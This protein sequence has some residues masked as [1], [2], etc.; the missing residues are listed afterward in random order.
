[1]R[2]TFHIRFAFLCCLYCF[3]GCSKQEETPGQY[4]SFDFRMDGSRFIPN[5]G[6]PSSA[7]SFTLAGTI[8][9][10][11]PTPLP[12]GGKYSFAIADGMGEKTVL[13]AGNDTSSEIIA[14]IANGGP[15]IQLLADSTSIY[16][17]HL[18]SRI[19]CFDHE[20]KA[21]WSSAIQG[22]PKANSI[23]AENTVIIDSDSGIAAIN[24]HT[25]KNVW[26]YPTTMSVVGMIYDNKSKLII[27]SLS[28]N[29]S[30]T[31]DS[32][33]C[34]TSS[35]TIKSSIVFETTRII[36]NLCLC[37]KEKGKIAFGYLGKP[38]AANNQRTMH[39]AVYSGIQSG[40]PKSVSD[41]ELP[42]LVTNL[43]SNGQ[44]LLSSGF[45]ETGG[46][47]QSG[48]DAFNADD[49]M[50]L[51][52]RRF[53]YPVVLPPAINEKYVYLSL[54]FSTQAE[55]TTQSIF[56]TLDLSNGKTLVELPV[57]GAKDGFV[58]GIPMPAGE[59]ELMLADR[60]RPVI[61]YLK[62]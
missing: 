33:L 2:Q 31:G 12:G 13:F 20:G 52:Q 58:N 6:V 11:P 24:T 54:T 16:S 22:F 62:P 36:S 41:H 14:T 7:T 45:R 23:I 51:W 32:I 25:G 39:V 17:V 61:Y 57:A 4:S 56:Y 40:N 55:V 50:K 48:I 34:F 29:N 35:G 43:A 18:G 3:T 5:I 30:D 27:A 59:G 49:T 44:I 53:S 19:N 9:T 46:D 15:I 38:G 60:S 21:V 10:T 8:L 26:V 47:L 28:F 1:V 37:G 42:Y